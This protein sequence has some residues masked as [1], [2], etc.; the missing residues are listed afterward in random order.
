MEKTKYLG[1]AGFTNQFFIII[2]IINKIE[3]IKV[4]IVKKNTEW[5]QKVETILVT[6]TQSSQNKVM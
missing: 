1:K 2:N 6:N 5:T 3:K 4:S